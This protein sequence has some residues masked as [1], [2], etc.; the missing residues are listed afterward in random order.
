MSLVSLRPLV[1]GLVWGK[2]Q[3]PEYRVRECRGPAPATAPEGSRGA[4]A[5]ST[6]AAEEGKG[7]K[8]A[9]FHNPL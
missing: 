4:G 7:D 1:P 9:L 6:V 5:A 2:P 8:W 3:V